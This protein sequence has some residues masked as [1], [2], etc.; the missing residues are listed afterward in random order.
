MKNVLVTGA[1][2]GIGLAIVKALLDHNYTVIAVSRNDENLNSIKSDRLRIF[3]VDLQNLEEIEA[4][5]KKLS[6]LGI[7]I[8]VLINNAGIGVFGNVE[9]LSWDN[10]RQVLDLNLSVPFYLTNYVIPKMKEQNYGRIINIGSDDDSKAE[11]GASAYCASKFG[12]L[13]LTQC[14]RLETQGYNI[15][16]TTISPGRVD[17]F[18]NSKYPGCRPNAL[19]DIDIAKQVIFVLDMDERCNI[20]E[21][22][23]SSN[24][25]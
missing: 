7:N 21:I 3:K 17:T 25:E 10:W 1:N 16:V 12:L 14:V 15:G 4:F 13:G 22:R 20:E 9:T 11:V 8:D 5:L 6:E 23:L 2:K 19:K 18:F 24:L